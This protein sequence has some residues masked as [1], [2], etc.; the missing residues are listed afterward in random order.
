[1]TQRIAFGTSGW[2][3]LMADDFTAV[4]VRRVSQALADHLAAQ[5]KAGGL[6]LIGFD[7]RFLGATF[8][9]HAAGV[10]LANGFHVGVGREPVPTPAIDFAVL[11]EKAVAGVCFTASHNPPEYQGFKY[12]AAWGGIARPDETDPIADRA[13]ALTDAQVRT[14]TAP[15]EPYDFR[16]A[17]LDRLVGLVGRSSPGL[18]LLVNTMHGAASRYLPELLSRLG[19]TVI[20]LNDTH[21]PL[22]GGLQPDPSARNLAGMGARME[23]GG[24]DLGLATDA[25]G[26]RFGVLDPTGQFMEPN[27]VLALLVDGLANDPQTLA[28]PKTVAMARVTGSIVE[29]VAKSKGFAV[30]KT[31]VGFKYLGKLLADGK[32]SFACE[33]SSGFAWAPH[34]PDKDGLLTCALMARLVAASRQSPRAMMDTLYAKVGIRRSRRLDL[35]L[36]PAVKDMLLHRLRHQPPGDFA[37]EEVTYVDQTDGFM[38]QLGTSGWVAFRP[39]GTEPMVRVYLDAEDD[40]HL[41]RLTQSAHDYIATCARG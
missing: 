2:R 4:N 11:K 22:F 12:I 9:R 34:V 7:T 8:A 26:D 6:V 32:A 29:K 23:A 13:N 24:F 37:G 21:D 3:G 15:A 40:A 28:G 27:E 33:E 38:L 18:R 17:Y 20:P 36:D 25:D 16:T 1:M 35:K 41:I 14:T 5:G 30:E 19:H 31:P 39:S 10:F